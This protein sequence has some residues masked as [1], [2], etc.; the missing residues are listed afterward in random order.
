[1]NTVN[2]KRFY[3]EL[4]KLLYA[5]TEVD[6]VIAPKEKEALYA[7]VR[8]ELAPA[9][10]HTDEFGT[11]AA[12]YA[13]TEFDFMDENSVDGET[14]LQSFLDFIDAHPKLIDQPM[15][16][17]CLRIAEKLADAYHKTNKKELELLRTLKQKLSAH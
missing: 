12:F 1:M 8:K 10:Q 17:S 11:N 3:S 7:I 5:V 14:A 6:G 13:E 9:E 4:G 16:N 2:Y 15:R